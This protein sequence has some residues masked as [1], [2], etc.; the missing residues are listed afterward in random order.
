[1]KNIWF[2]ERTLNFFCCLWKSPPLFLTFARLQQV[3]VWDP[4]GSLYLAI[5][6]MI[7]IVSHADLAE[8]TIFGQLSA[9]KLAAVR[10]VEVTT[11]VANHCGSICLP[12]KEALQLFEFCSFPPC[13]DVFSLEGLEPLTLFTLSFVWASL[14]NSVNWVQSLCRAC[15]L[16]PFFLRRINI[17]HCHSMPHISSSL[18]GDF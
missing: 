6:P 13:P 10:W 18:P 5:L 1:M 8:P 7:L 17:V 4:C 15:P 3:P 9:W 2:I 12:S 11:V 16:N 14:A